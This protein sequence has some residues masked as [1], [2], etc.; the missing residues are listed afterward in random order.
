VADLVLE[1]YS[2]GESGETIAV[3]SGLSHWRVYRFLRE[4]GVLRTLKQASA[5]REERR[6]R[7][8]NA[9]GETS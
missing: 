5:L 2:A 7:E 9:A 4:R 6:R 1:R 3:D 8:Y